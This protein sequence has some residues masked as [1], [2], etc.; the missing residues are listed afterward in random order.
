MGT[1]WFGWKTR[2]RYHP[3]TPS[4]PQGLL[5]QKGQLCKSVASDIFFN[6]LTLPSCFFN[7]SIRHKPIAQTILLQG[8]PGNTQLLL[9]GTLNIR[10]LGL[11]E[12]NFQ[13]CFQ[14]SDWRTSAH[15]HAYR[16]IT[17]SP[18]L[19]PVLHYQHW[20]VSAVLLPSYSI[21]SYLSMLHCYLL[22]LLL[23]TVFYCF[24]TSL[25][26]Y[27]PLPASCLWFRVIDTSPL[28]IQIKMTILLPLPLS[29][30]IYYFWTL[31]LSDSCHF[32]RKL[33]EKE[34]SDEG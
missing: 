10:S 31:T 16:F 6:S 27:L 19:C 3:G 8:V 13:T 25:P 14:S 18:S 5:C 4:R 32:P 20:I 33:K 12:L 1:K 29:Q 11:V 15:H 9:K 34:K 30:F 7:S 22:F 28:A 23:W 24:Q 21:S 2:Q 17:I 26:L